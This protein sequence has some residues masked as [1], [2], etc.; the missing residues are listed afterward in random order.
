M[1]DYYSVG[2]TGLQAD[3]KDYPESWK[4][5]AKVKCLYDKYSYSADLDAADTIGFFTIPKDATPIDAMVKHADLD[6]SGG[7]IDLG[8]AASA[9][10]STEAADDNGFIDNADVATAADV[11]KSSDNLASPPGIGKTFAADVMCEVKIEGDTDVTSGDVEVWV[12][13]VID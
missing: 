1:S 9:D 5:G 7:T 12:L 4:R 8:W 2:E 11:V 10:G 6:T 13:Y 3:P